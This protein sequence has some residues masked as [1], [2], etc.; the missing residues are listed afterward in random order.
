MIVGIGVDIVE[1]ER[2]ESALSNPRTGARF[3]ERVFTPNEVAY[4]ERR[5]NSQESYSARFAAKEAVMKAL[6][7]AYGW[8]EIEVARLDGPPTVVLYGRASRR[9]AELG[10]T[11]FHLALSH[12]AQ[13][14]IAYVV[15]ER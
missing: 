3:R 6:G 15:A 2:I 9:A 5:R 14:A 10:V 8:R 1:V 11:R 13:T 4:C 12:T 7:R